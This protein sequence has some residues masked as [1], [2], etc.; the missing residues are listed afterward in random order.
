V[1]TPSGSGD[2]QLSDSQQ[3]ITTVMK[4]IRS[5]RMM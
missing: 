2:Q 4:P 1:T 5:A 3:P